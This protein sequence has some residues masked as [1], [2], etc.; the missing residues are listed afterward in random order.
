MNRRKSEEEGGRME[1]G[2][3]GRESEKESLREEERERKQRKEKRGNK[4]VLFLDRYIQQSLFLF[5]LPLQLDFFREEDGTGR[6][7]VSP[8]AESNH[9]IFTSLFR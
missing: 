7:L 5:P 6:S 8:P 3:N 2:D 9:G 4:H 1:Q